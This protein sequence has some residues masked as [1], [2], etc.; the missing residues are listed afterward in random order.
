MFIPFLVGVPGFEPGTPWSQT[1]CANRAALHPEL[2]STVSN[3]SAERGGFEPPVPS[4]VHTLSKR[5]QSAT[6]SPL[7]YDGSN[8]RTFWMH[9]SS[10]T[11]I[12]KSQLI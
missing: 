2:N 12:K 7:Q 8:I 3:S 11:A 6:L 9:Q 4:Q 5:T 1:R 10:V